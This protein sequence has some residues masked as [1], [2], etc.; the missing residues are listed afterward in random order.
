MKL[1][2]NIQFAL[3]VIAILWLVYLADLFLPV[4][5]RHY[6]LRPRQISGLAGIV[7]APLLHGSLRHLAANS[8]ALFFLLIISLS[9]SRKLTLSALLMIAIVGGGL[10]WLIGGSNTVHIGASG[11]IFGL[12]GFLMSLGL[13]RREWGSLALSLVVF[14]FYGGALFTAFI[15]GPGISWSGHVCG[16]LS[17]VMAAWWL[18]K[19]KGK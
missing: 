10:V 8:G 11:I 5:L 7:F 3:T 1:S 18:R 16:F 13:F 15:P 6:G 17:G 12:I 9:F 4:D 14:F 2:H 19:A